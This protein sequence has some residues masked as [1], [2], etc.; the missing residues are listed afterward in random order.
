MNKI[1][2]KTFGH[3]YG[4]PPED[5]HAVFDAR[6]I[7]NPHSVPG[8]ERLTGYDGRV[9]EFIKAQ[10]GSDVLLAAI[11][12][13]LD[14]MLESLV[15]GQLNGNI[16]VIAIGCKG[17]RQRSVC[18]A[19]LCEDKVRG[20]LAAR[21]HVVSIGLDHRDLELDLSHEFAKGVAYGT[22]C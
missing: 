15:A 5:A 10:P 17:G 12:Q 8:M 1:L 19:R 2:I 11:V 18:I 6:H 22:A 4:P 3:K 21:Q 16:L 20:W 9:E 13:Q 7:P 14:Q